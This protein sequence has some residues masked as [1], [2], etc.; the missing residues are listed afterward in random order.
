MP[1]TIEMLPAESMSKMTPKVYSCAM[2]SRVVSTVKLIVAFFKAGNDS[3]PQQ[4]FPE[5]Y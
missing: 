3:S 4:N 2:K 1:V 5:V